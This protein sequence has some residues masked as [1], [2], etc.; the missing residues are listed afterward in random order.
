MPQEELQ[1]NEKDENECL[2]MHIINDKK[3]ILTNSYN[4][5]K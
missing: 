1:I 4:Y 5:R 3:V 2:I